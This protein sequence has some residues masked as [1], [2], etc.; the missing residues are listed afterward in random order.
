MKI[1]LESAITATDEVK[2]LDGHDLR[3]QKA[4]EAHR[5]TKEINTKSS[6]Q[7]QPTGRDSP[8][9]GAVQKQLSPESLEQ[10]KAKR[11]EPHVLTALRDLTEARTMQH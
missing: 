8:G 4:N 2:G 1:K 11:R 9:T 5:N 6:A 3:Q 7:S 10:Q